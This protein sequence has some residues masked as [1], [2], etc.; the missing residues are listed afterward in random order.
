M[1]MGHTHNPHYLLVECYN[2]QMNHVCTD[3]TRSYENSAID[4]RLYSLR[5]SDFCL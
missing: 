3:L 4:H 2:Y 1:F 5:M